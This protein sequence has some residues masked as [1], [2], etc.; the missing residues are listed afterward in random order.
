MHGEAQVSTIAR[1]HQV[2]QALVTDKPPSVG[3]Y[4]IW[5]K[6]IMPRCEPIAERYYGDPSKWSLQAYDD[7]NS[8]GETPPIGYVRYEYQIL[9]ELNYEKGN[10]FRLWYGLLRPL[11]RTLWH[12]FMKKAKQK[13]E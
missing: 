11:E 12:T 2:P 13:I 4:P 7:D 1:D 6:W 8:F 9:E 3:M 5:D 10:L